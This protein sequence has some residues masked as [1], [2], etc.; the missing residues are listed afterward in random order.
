M[1][2]SSCGC[3]RYPC[4]FAKDVCTFRTRMWRW[5]LVLGLYHVLRWI[6]YSNQGMGM[7]WRLVILDHCM[8]CWFSFFLVW[9][10]VCYLWVLDCGILCESGLN[11]IEFYSIRFA[12]S[13]NIMDQNDNQHEDK[14]WVNTISCKYNPMQCHPRTN[15]S[16]WSSHCFQ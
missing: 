1:Q 2:S 6:W 3:S 8:A 16:Q 4:G 13:N 10:W 9:V 11:K 12:I 15:K 5:Y 7:G 14:E